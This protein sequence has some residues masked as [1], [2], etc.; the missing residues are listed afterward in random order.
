MS[1]VSTDWL[2]QNIKNANIRI[3]DCSW[4]MPNSDRIG[5]DEFPLEHIPNSN[6]FDIDKFSDPKGKFPHTIPPKEQ[7]EKLCS[8]LGLKN[9]DHIIVYDSLGILSSPR[10]WWMFNYFGHNKI[11]ILDGGFIKWK[12]EKKR[13]EK[14][15]S[16]N[17]SRSNFTCS[18]KETLLTKIE[19]IKENINSK[20]SNLVDARSK[21]RFLG[22]EPEPRPGLRGG[23]IEN[24]C[25]LPWTEC[26]D[27]KTKC[28]LTKE[29]LKKKFS[30]INIDSNS[31]VIFSCGSGISACITAKAFE[32][33]GGKNFSIYDGSW[34]EW[35]SQ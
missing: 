17:Y 11:S 31:K 26:I 21:G 20:I 5:K 28:F 25:N 35:A 2:D 16:K 4:H 32:L 15:L 12:L 33:I 19:Q 27:Q 6:F 7:F 34:T 10:V 29:E 30:K 8:E 18:I 9:S 22:I 3:L 24:S 1:L 23:S 14:G 13:V